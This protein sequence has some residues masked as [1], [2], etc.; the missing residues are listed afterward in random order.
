MRVLFCVVDGIP[1]C[2]LCVCRVVLPP[3]CYVCEAF[4]GLLGERVFVCSGL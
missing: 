2:C 1:V 3:F 4:V